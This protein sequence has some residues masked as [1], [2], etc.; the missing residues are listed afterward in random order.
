MINDFNPRTHALLNA[1]QWNLHLKSIHL[2]GSAAGCTRKW[3]LME[4]ES[5]NEL[6]AY[7]LYIRRE[8]KDFNIYLYLTFR[9]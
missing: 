5:K 8:Q 6:N 7:G 3:V 2:T 9:R 1:S 4:I